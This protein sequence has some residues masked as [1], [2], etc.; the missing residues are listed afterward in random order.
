MKCV[1][2]QLG[3]SVTFGSVA[4]TCRVTNNTHTHSQTHTLTSGACIATNPSLFRLLC[5][6]Q[7]QQ[8]FEA[9][10]RSF[11]QLSVCVKE[12]S[13]LMKMKIALPISYNSVIG[14]LQM[15]SKNQFLS[16]SAARLSFT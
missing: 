15:Q 4:M 5:I 12:R 6:T 9:W 10:Q 8:L 13:F 11:A 16:F 3:W 7:Q 14:E 1:N 2:T